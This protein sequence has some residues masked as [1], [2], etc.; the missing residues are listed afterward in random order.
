MDIPI[1]DRN[2]SLF[3]DALIGDLVHIPKFV[4]I[5]SW[6]ARKI[7]NVL[8]AGDNYSAVLLLTEPNKVIQIICLKQRASPSEETGNAVLSASAPSI[9][10]D[11]DKLPL[12]PN[13]SS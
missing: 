5:Y 12:Y 4:R 3:K 7:R 8:Q 10:A 2:L 11:H 1:E 9:N 6:Q 13:L